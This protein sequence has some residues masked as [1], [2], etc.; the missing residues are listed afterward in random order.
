MGKD[1][2]RGSPVSQVR[3]EGNL[4]GL[5]ASI[6]LQV[7]LRQTEGGAFKTWGDEGTGTCMGGDPSPGESQS[8][9]AK[10]QGSIQMLIL[11]GQN[12]C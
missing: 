8:L 1:F 6:R 5:G 3:R 9:S 12:R 7:E 4:P 2:T 10:S 11:P